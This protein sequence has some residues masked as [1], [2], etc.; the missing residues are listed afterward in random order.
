M[1]IIGNY[2]GREVLYLESNKDYLSK[3]P[4]SNWQCLLIA[5][6]DYDDEQLKVFFNRAVES[7]ILGI[8]S[9]G[10]YGNEIDSRLTTFKMDLFEQGRDVDISMWG[11][12]ASDLSETFWSCFGSP[13]LP[14]RT[15]YDDL[16][17]VCISFDSLDYKDTL[18]DYLQKFN[19]G[20]LP[21]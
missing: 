21:G 1:E 8:L 17:L 20:W 18:K 16:K 15:N 11:D 4:T 3:L 12:S 2:Y 9:Q 13:A 7:D 19:N 5:N 6:E 14:N 10:K